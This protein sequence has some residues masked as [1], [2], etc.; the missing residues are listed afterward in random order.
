MEKLITALL[1]IAVSVSAQDFEQLYEKAY[2]LETAKGQTEEAL[3]LYKQIVNSK[4]TDDNRQTII[5]SLER[6]LAIQK[7]DGNK[8]LQ[9]K[10][11]H[12]EIDPDILGHIIDTF[13]EPDAY[14]HS[15]K[16]CQKD[17][18]P[19]SYAMSYPGDGL[20]INV[21][22]GRI[23]ELSF[24]KPN[25]CTHGIKVGSTLEDVVAAFP[26]Q[27]TVTEPS[28]SQNKTEPG[29]LYMNYGVPGTGS[30]ATGKGIRLFIVKNRVFGLYLQNPPKWIKSTPTP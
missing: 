9:D 4:A 26:P 8:T 1:L 30:Y 20:T 28:N 2:F 15:N 25:Y 6:M 11:D 5:H 16:V 12:F 18:L 24:E 14:I 13:G 10:V 7:R 23:T 22:L 21:S 17:N 27:E 19:Q 3:D 29:V